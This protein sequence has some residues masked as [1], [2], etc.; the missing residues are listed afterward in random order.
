MSDTPLPNLHQLTAQIVAAH[1]ANAAV[2]AEALPS[3]IHTVFQALSAAGSPTA[4][5]DV[6]RPEPAVPI[7]KSVFPDHII[8]LEDGKSFKTLRRHLQNVYNL[9]PDQY[10]ARWGLPKEYPMVAPAYAEHRSKLAKSFGLGRARGESAAT[11]DLAE[12]DKASGAKKRG[13]KAEETR[14][15]QD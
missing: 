13:R 14:T 11:A 8:C 6:P 7:K 9:T 12:D 3:L 4:P 5:G 1:V 2:E 10:R 15:D